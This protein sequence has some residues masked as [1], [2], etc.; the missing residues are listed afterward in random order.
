MYL[1]SFTNFAYTK[2]FETADQAIAHMKRAGFEAV[3]MTARGDRI[4]EFR[5]LSGQFI[6]NQI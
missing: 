3:L 5:P 6:Y 4:G 1:V 2:A